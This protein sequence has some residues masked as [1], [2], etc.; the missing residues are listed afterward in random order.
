MEEQGGFHDLLSQVRPVVPTPQ[1]GKFM[2]H[3]VP[4]FAGRGFLCQPLRNN[5][6]RPEESDCRRYAGLGRNQNRDRTRQF[7]LGKRRLQFPAQELGIDGG[8]TPAQL[9]DMP[10]P[11]AYTQQSQE[12]QQG[13]NS[14]YGLCPR[15]RYGKQRFASSGSRNGLRT[16]CSHSGDTQHGQHGNGDQSR[17]P[18]REPGTRAFGRKQAHGQRKQGGQ[19]YALSQAIKHAVE[20]HGRH[21][22]QIGRQGH[23]DSP[24][25][26]P[27]SSLWPRSSRRRFNSIA[28]RLESSSRLST[29]SSWES[30]KNR[31]SRLRTSDRVASLRPTRG[32]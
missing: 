27:A 24:P 20:R 29:S 3:N 8:A 6:D 15:S 1:M 10:Q 30:L 21:P 22:I 17:K 25:F 26:C 13:P 18:N 11:R 19:G 32:W 23:H 5:H 12:S 9:M 14:K 2:E 31:L 7:Q 16:S 28:S 4:Q